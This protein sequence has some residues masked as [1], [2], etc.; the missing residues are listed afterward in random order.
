MYT[1]PSGHIAFFVVTMLI[2]AV[3]GAAAGVGIGYLAGY[4]GT[5]L[6]AWGIG[7]A[8]IGAAV[9]TA[10]GMAVSYAATGS[11]SSSFSEVSKVLLAKGGG[12]CFV[13]GT[14]ILTSSGHVAI[15]DIRA[16]DWVWATDPETGET[17]LKS[18]V[19]TFRNET[20]EEV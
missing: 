9:G 6:I 3:V 17:A 18:V 16:G 13:A 2:G 20:T 8:L 15:E 7:G 12:H 14:A 5:D 19:Q 4:E 1:D 10:V 11:V